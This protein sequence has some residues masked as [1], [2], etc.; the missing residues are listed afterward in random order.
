MNKLDNLHE[1]VMKESNLTP[2]EIEDIKN[3][4]SAQY[5][6]YKN[7]RSRGLSHKVAMKNLGR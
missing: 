5:K 4:T 6:A 3:F 2:A 1:A 7:D